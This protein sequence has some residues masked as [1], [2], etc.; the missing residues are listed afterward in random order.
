[1]AAKSAVI[2]RSYVPRARSKPQVAALAEAARSTSR[3]HGIP[4]DAIV[5][6]PRN[7]RTT[8]TEQAINE[9]AQSLREDGQLQPVL[10]RRTDSNLGDDDQPKFELIAGERRWR[11]AQRAGLKTIQAAIWEVSDEESLRLALIENWHRAGLTPAEH[12][13]G[14]EALAEAAGNV[15]VRELARKLRL[16]PSTISERLKVRRDPLVWPAVEDGHIPL[17]HAFRLRR[18]PALA[19]SYLVGRAVAERPSRDLLEEW[20]EHARD[21]HRSAE[22][23]ASLATAAH[24]ARGVRQS[25]TPDQV[26]RGQ[27][28]LDSLADGLEVGGWEVAQAI[29]ARLGELLG[30]LRGLEAM[31][32]KKRGRSSPNS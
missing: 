8:F 17:G 18:A 30:E 28:Y 15:G 24:G 27:M 4:V 6:N 25:N 32:P 12:V 29:H 14:L 2:A 20:I 19:R 26:E 11:A 21:E 9:L 13:A 7:P 23:R 3:L 16:A 10:V 22:S 31:R 5:P 1:V